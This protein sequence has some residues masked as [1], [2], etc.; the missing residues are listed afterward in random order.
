MIDLQF[1]YPVL[2]GQAELF[3]R[4]LADVVAAQG[5]RVLE[6]PPDG[7]TEEQRTTAAQWLSRDGQAVGKERVLLCAGGHHAVMVSM[8]ALGLKQC[9][10][11]VDPLTYSNFKTQAASLGNKLF[12]CAGDEQGMMPSALAAA[13]DKHSVQAVY[14][15]P[16]VHNPMGTVMPESRR[17]EI[18]EVARKHDLK[19]IDD[20]AYRFTAANPP[21]SFAT[22][23][24]ERAFSVWSFTKPVA[25]VMKL[26]F[27]T[28]P[29][30][31]AKV[32][33]EVLDVTTSGA[34][35]LFAELGVRMLRSGELDS[36]LAT[37]RKEGERRQNMA[38]EILEGIDVQGHPTSFHI[39]IPLPEDKP[40]DA[41]CEQLKADGVLVSSSD[42][43]RATPSV[44]ANGMRIALGAARDAATLQEGLQRV[45]ERIRD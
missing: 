45:R 18:C 33:M 10:I 13:V 5:A 35:G 42:A 23:A 4:L 3:S 27:L 2:Q 7:G 41:V 38:R 25:P 9:G 34:S 15:M 14:L 22:L 8:L 16:T 24:P 44:K 39:W 6:A 31:Y 19:I 21:P 11:A 1:N 12:P 26:G 30:P 37:K 28:F 32:L 17:R 40:A 43:Y 36:L 29:E 20:D